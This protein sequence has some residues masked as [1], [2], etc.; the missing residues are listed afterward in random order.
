MYVGYEPD[1]LGVFYSAKPSTG[2][3]MSGFPSDKARLENIRRKK[4]M[5]GSI[6]RK[7]SHTVMKPVI[8]STPVEL[9]CCNLGPTH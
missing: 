1:A 6:L 4:S 8:C 5:C 2:T 7:A 3:I 9:R